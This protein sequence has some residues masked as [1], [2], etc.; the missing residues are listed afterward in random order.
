MLYLGQLLPMHWELN[1]HIM[2]TYFALAKLQCGYDFRKGHSVWARMYS[3]DFA[4]DLRES[5]KAVA[6]LPFAPINCSCGPPLKRLEGRLQK[7]NN[8]RMGAGRP[9]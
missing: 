5:V 7:S 9:P 3:N 4:L 6:R 8:K 2:A 1:H